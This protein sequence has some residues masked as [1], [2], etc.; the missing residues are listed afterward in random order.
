MYLKAFLFSLQDS[1]YSESTRKCCL[2]SRNAFAEEAELSVARC[3]YSQG[4]YSD[5]RDNGL[6]TYSLIRRLMRFRSLEESL[7][8]WASS[9]DFCS[10]DKKNY[11]KSLRKSSGLGTRRRDFA[12][13]FALRTL[14]RAGRLWPSSVEFRKSATE[15]VPQT[16]EPQCHQPNPL[17]GLADL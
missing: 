14:H 4:H 9:R 16:L 10:E 17:H 6:K 8:G 2:L 12:A 3:R 11:Q 7:F 5:K 1:R 13:D 15:S